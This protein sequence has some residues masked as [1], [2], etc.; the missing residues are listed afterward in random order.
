[1][2]TIEKPTGPD[3]RLEDDVTVEASRREQVIL[4]EMLLDQRFI[5]G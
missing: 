2:A 4:G 3:F 5:R 1:M